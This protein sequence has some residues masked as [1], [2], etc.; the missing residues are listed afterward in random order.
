MARENINTGSSANDGTGDTLRTAGNKIN[1]NFRELY[2][3]LGGDSSVIYSNVTLGDNSITFE[4]SLIDNFETVL[5]VINP[6][7]DNI[8]TL[9]DSSGEVILDSAEQSLWNKHLY[10]TK[11]DGALK[12]HGTSGT[13][14]YVI[15]YDGVLSSGNLNIIIPDL[16]DSDTWVFE[17]HTQTL[18]N[19][20]LTSP[21]IT[22]PVI[23]SK[24]LDTSGNPSL[25]IKTVASAVNYLEIEAATTGNNPSLN[26]IGSETNID[27]LLEPKGTGTVRPGAPLRFG[28]T[29]YITNGAISTNVA[30][31]LMNDGS[32]LTM[33]LA[34]ASDG[35]MM[36]IVNINTGTATITPATFA[37]G[38]SFDLSAGAA[39]QLIYLAEDGWHLLGVDS[40]GGSLITITP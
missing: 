11:I 31:A 30:V 16:A 5:T 32:P 24:L 36:T 33:T 21:T 40:T 3:I 37:Q 18:T 27:L 19:K 23:N 6:T 7:K 17:D 22:D 8:I 26:A 13:D 20:T 15:N 39:T 29:A 1:N 38:S 4:G 12:L 14:Y 35:Q 25:G 28:Q 9:P 34:N 10:N 2:N